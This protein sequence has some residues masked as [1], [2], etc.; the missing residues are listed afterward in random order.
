MLIIIVFVCK[1]P[2]KCACLQLTLRQ[3]CDER[4]KQLFRRQMASHDPYYAFRRL[5]EGLVLTGMFECNRGWVIIL[6]SKYWFFCFSY[7]NNIYDRCKCKK[8][9][10]FNR[11]VQNPISVHLELFKTENKGWGVRCLHDLPKGAFIATY[12][13][14]VLPPK[15]A[16][17]QPQVCIS[18]RLLVCE[19]V[20]IIWIK[21]SYIHTLLNL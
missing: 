10:C 13:G 5:D 2:K 1:D 8:Q 7:R 15:F 4:N 6:L 16:Y 17:V 12:S 14:M 9:S 20:I 21:E 3:T 11:V 18:W 19:L